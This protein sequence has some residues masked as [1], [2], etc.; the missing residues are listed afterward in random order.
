[1]KRAYYHF[2]TLPIGW[3]VPISFV[4]RFMC[5]GKTVRTENHPVTNSKFPYRTQSQAEQAALIWCDMKNQAQKNSR[6]AGGARAR[7]GAGRGAAK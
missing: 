2:K 3:P 5:N 7:S 4:I 1:M 6:P